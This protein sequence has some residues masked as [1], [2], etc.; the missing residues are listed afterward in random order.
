M[1]AKALLILAFVGI[2]GCAGTQGPSPVP[3]ANRSLYT[4]TVWLL[5]RQPR[6]GTVVRVFN[7][8]KDTSNVSVVSSFIADKITSTT[9][10][11]LSEHIVVDRTG[12][13][14]ATAKFVA[15]FLPTAD[16]HFKTSSH[17]ERDAKN[18]TSQLGPERTP[19][20]Q[21][22]YSL[23]SGIKSAEG[24]SLFESLRSQTIATKNPPAGALYIVT[25]V[26]LSPDVTWVAKNNR[27]IGLSVKESAKIATASIDGSI[28][29]N[30]SNE[31]NYKGSPMVITVVMRR[32]GRDGNVIRFDDNSAGPK[33]ATGE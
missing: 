13:I 9:A 1:R 27:D 18:V 26:S 28:T 19:F 32:I 29:F 22:I 25:S 11:A 12:G 33:V 17:I 15:S 5:H 24:S 21:S 3:I 4:G 14:S 16:A 8:D 7:N 2:S 10:P 30:G 31:A 6:P 23:D 20:L